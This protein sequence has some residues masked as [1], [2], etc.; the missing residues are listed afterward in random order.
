M[1]STTR[2]T[3]R[4]DDYVKYRP[5]YP[6]QVFEAL[7]GQLVSPERATVAD[8]GSGTGIFSKPLV[9]QGFTVFAVEP[10]AAMRAAAERELGNSPRFHSV[11]ATAEQT[12]LSDQSVDA[13]V[14]AQAFHWFDPPAARAEFRR[15]LKPGGLVALIWNDRDETTS[16]FARD[17]ERLMAACAIDYEDVKATGAR[18]ADAELLARFFGPDGYEV[19]CFDNEQVLDFEGFNGRILS[20]SYMPKPPHPDYSRLATE[21]EA[22]FR[23][24]APAGTVTIEYTT[25]LYLGRL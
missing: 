13:V 20:A 8:I 23:R 1:N 24:H 14:A 6:R 11:A 2:F 12:A 17:Y 4:V 5:H 3:D 25:R 16:E 21:I 18:A 19:L 10:N 7:C 22:I 9:E 15:I